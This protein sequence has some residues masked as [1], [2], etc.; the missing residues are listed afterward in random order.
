MENSTESFKQQRLNVCK[1]CPQSQHTFGV[2]LTCGK[3]MTPVKNVSCG[4]KLT[5]KTALKGQECP[6][7]RWA[8]IKIPTSN[9]SSEESVTLSE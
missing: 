3:F 6:Q 8:D 4:C 7:K 1:A 5:W 2:G 9:S